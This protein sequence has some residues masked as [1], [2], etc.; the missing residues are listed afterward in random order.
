MPLRCRQPDADILAFELSKDEWI[1]LRE[2]N[3]EKRHLRMPCC[4]SKVVLK[5]SGL[6]TQFFAHSRKGDCTSARETAEHLLA[7]SIVAKSAKRAGWHV[8]TEYRDQTPDGEVWIADVFAT[9]GNVKIAF[10]IQWSRQDE[11]TTKYRQDRYKKSGVRALW[12][13]RQSNILVDESVPTFCL[14]FEESTHSFSVHVPYP[15]LPLDTFIAGALSK[16]LHFLPTNESSIPV[17][18]YGGYKECWSCHRDTLLVSSLK[19]VISEFI[20]TATDQRATLNFFDSYEYSKPLCDQVLTLDMLREHGIG[21]VR[22]RYSKTENKE[23]LSNG[24]FHCDALSGRHFDRDLQYREKL[25]YSAPII[26]DSALA[27]RFAQFNLASLTTGW[28]YK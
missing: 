7:K 15:I 5:T 16:R 19:F 10:E 24:C 12:L 6:G 22:F 2:G 11:E 8:I 13:M 14:D 3:A 4:D 9:K 17:D 25:I 18:V 23:Y 1:A 26:F 28:Q 20:P 27:R 21:E